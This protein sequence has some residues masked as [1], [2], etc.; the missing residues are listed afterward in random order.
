MSN[1][2][3]LE[4][5]MLEY[6]ADCIRRNGYS[7]SI[8]DIRSA[9]GIKSTSTVHTYLER[10]EQ[11]G[12]IQKENGKSRTLRVE[13]VTAPRKK[14]V[15]VPIVGRVAAGAPILAVENHEGYIDFP[16]PNQKSYQPGVLF[17]L[18]IRGESMIDAGILSGDIVVVERMN[19]AENG[20][21]VV[22]MIEDEA[23]V[24]TFYA[25]NGHY[26]LQ[27]ENETMEPII[28]KDLVILGKVIASLR[29]YN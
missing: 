15:R 12:Y 16:L 3:E 28:V 17:A 27:P 2:T 10:L 18:R 8:R 13:D 5:Q 24:K 11:K 9:L 19:Y 26:R 25:E 23:T 1:T 21:I 7:P 4:E 20:D 22:A 29:Y 6:I 14:V